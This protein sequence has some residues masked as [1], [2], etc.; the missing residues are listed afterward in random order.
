MSLK[1]KR[2]GAPLGLS[3]NLDS[4]VI[5]DNMP[6][7][8]APGLY[9]GSIHC[10]FNEV[11]MRNAGVT[12]I[13]NTSGTPATYPNTFTYLSISIRDK[14]YSNLL[15]CIPACNIFI[16]AGL[17]SGGSVLVHCTGGRSRS[18][19]IITA[20]LMS[21]KEILFKEA[22]ATVKKARSLAS[23]NAGFET[24][25]RAYGEMKHDVHRAHQLLL[26][27]HMER[28][29]EGRRSQETAVRRLAATTLSNPLRIKLMQPD[30]ASVYIIP[31][32]RGSDMQY[33]CRKCQCP[34]FVTS[35]IICHTP[36][37]NQR[38]SGRT[39]RRTESK[40]G[41]SSHEECVG[42]SGG[43]KSRG[44]AASTAAAVAAAEEQGAALLTAALGRD[45]SSGSGSS[46]NNDDD[47]GSNLIASSNHVL[48]SSSDTAA[49]P[50]S[51][52]A[53]RSSDATVGNISVTREITFDG[54]TPA[55][56][57]TRR[58][59]GQSGAKGKGFDFHDNSEGANSSGG[60][61]VSLASLSLRGESGR[62]AA[63]IGADSTSA[64]LPR[65]GS[66][67]GQTET[68]GGKDQH[69]RSGRSGGS[70]G[71][72]ESGSSSSSSSKRS[73]RGSGRDSR[74][75]GQQ[76]QQIV[77]GG[78]EGLEIPR[79][80]PQKWRPEDRRGWIDRMKVLECGITRSEKGRHRP[81]IV[82][83]VDEAAAIKVVNRNCTW[84]L[85]LCCFFCCS[86]CVRINK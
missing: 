44:D 46:G 15:S 17:E 85:F 60:E 27:Q 74:N 2:K 36:E 4:S 18:A 10:S 50:G 34:L 6:V 22:F 43:S 54:Q 33:V 84:S 64:K 26:R 61:D 37:D 55:A 9:M 31:P 23:C 21:S 71:S 63:D 3:L 79:T 49:A 14:D 51:V 29:A 75:S 11:G 58:H 8:I 70:G 20:F 25:L 56:P 77:V 67:S 48:V 76:Q 38:S 80:P 30:T 73:S 12:H 13:I 72:G 68:F 52:Y 66:S 82:A 78:R 62:N 24:Q 81:S 86:F 45:S 28:V 41:S 1:L 39:P 65:E 5:Q 7:P 83:D 19:A 32:L 16:E 53:F 40:V 59:G 69:G 57:M 42:S 47:D 35:S